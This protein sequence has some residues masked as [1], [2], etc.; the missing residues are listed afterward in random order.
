MRHAQAACMEGGR[1]HE[2]NSHKACPPCLEPSVNI[3]SNSVSS[4][5]MCS[6]ATNAL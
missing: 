2:A 3:A 1:P 4:L 6:H 5:P